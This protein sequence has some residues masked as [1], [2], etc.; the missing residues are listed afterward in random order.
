MSGKS[1]TNNDVHMDGDQNT[2]QDDDDN[3]ER[4][5]AQEG[6][7]QP[8]RRDKGKGK[9]TAR[10]IA[11]LD[12]FPAAPYDLGQ[13]RQQTWIN[14]GIGCMNCAN[15][16]CTICI[17]FTSHFMVGIRNNH[18]RADRKLMARDICPEIFNDYDRLYDTARRTIESDRDE[19]DEIDGKLTRLNNYADRIERELDDA[20]ARIKELEAS[21]DDAHRHNRRKTR[22][23]LSPGR[24]ASETTSSQME[25]S[26]GMASQP[27][28]NL[29]VNSGLR[30][31]YYDLNS[32]YGDSEASDAQEPPRYTNAADKTTIDQ[33]RGRRMTPEFPP[34]PQAGPSSYSQA[35]SAH[36]LVGRL[37][38]PTVPRGNEPPMI[39]ENSAAWAEMV[40]AAQIPD[41]WEAYNSC[42]SVVNVA[43][44][45]ASDKKPMRGFMRAAL[46]TW[47]APDWVKRVRNIRPLPRITVADATVVASSGTTAAPHL[48][49]T[50]N[51]SVSSPTMRTGLANRTEL[52][53]TTGYQAPS[54]DAPPEAWCAYDYYFRHVKAMS[55]GLGDNPLDLRT[56]R[57]H[58]LIRRTGPSPAV[59]DPTLE[60]NRSVYTERATTLLAMPGRY[61]AVIQRLGLTVPSVYQ[62]F[63]YAGHLDNLSVE[64]VAAHL[65][66]CGVSIEMANDAW[67]F[68]RQWLLDPRNENRP[69]TYPTRQQLLAL[70][71]SQYPPSAPNAPLLLRN[72]QFY[73]PPGCPPEPT[74][75]RSKRPRHLA[76]ASR[77][78]YNTNAAILRQLHAVAT[79]LGHTTVAMG[80]PTQGQSTSVAPSDSMADRLGPPSL[81]SSLPFEWDDDVT[82]EDNRTSHTVSLGGTIVPPAY[83]HSSSSRPQLGA[84]AVTQTAASAS[85]STHPHTRSTSLR[86]ATTTSFIPEDITMSP[87]IDTGSGVST[88]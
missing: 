67:L 27:Q 25:S 58:R 77:G 31:D 10:T 39:P 78:G 1:P 43:N 34:L 30:A 5:D 63:H 44:Q 37:S 50:T 86:P 12:T 16:E 88:P 26:M 20:R 49:A 65:A 45:L 71:P 54:M 41:N 57:G 51:D 24:P 56:R 59:G 11:E 4:R 2:P 83:L 84:S 75:V 72:P 14:T 6:E 82:E 79:T 74:E 46:R 29:S 66:A 81:A 70:P 7:G 80:D 38:T 35:A 33:P 52:R 69:N 9:A 40:Q 47:R 62:P 3:R 61:Q 18:A 19:I 85:G 42:R 73:F 15:T 23:S 68:A 87:V 60:R 28:S 55:A 21:Q 64:D 17:N 32:D 22:L 13:P 48:E 36:S 8:S 76:T 53:P